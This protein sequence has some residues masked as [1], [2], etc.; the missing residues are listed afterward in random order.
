MAFKRG[1]VVLV[2]YPFTDL[3]SSK[4]RPAVIMSGALYHGLQPDLVLVALT[5]NIAA[6]TE[7]LDYV[8]Q[9]WASANLRFPTAFKPVVATLEPG[10]V[11]FTIGALSQRDLQEIESRLRAA[12]EL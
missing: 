12:L 5:S 10:L 2:R 8:L 1:D 7:S 9:D 4:T 6:A 3:S 11:V